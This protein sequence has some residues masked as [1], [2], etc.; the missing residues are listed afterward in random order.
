MN[1]NSNCWKWIIAFL[2]FVLLGFGLSPYFC[3]L[4][5]NN[6]DWQDLLVNVHPELIGM[7]FTILVLDFITHKYLER[8]EKRRILRNL[9]NPS[10]YFSIDAYYQ[11]KNKEWLTD[12]S[13]VNA[14]LSYSVLKEIDLSKVNFENVVLKKAHLERAIFVEA[15]LINAVFDEAHLEGCKFIRAHIEGAS[16]EESHLSGTDFTD[17]IYNSKTCWK[18]A[19]YDSKTN[20]P[21]EFSPEDAGCIRLDPKDIIT[22][23]NSSTDYNQH[24]M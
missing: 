20:W 7:G 19:T 12:G 5:S 24:M 14:Q 22:G 3:T 10:K 1:S 9:G 18:N 21:R 11:A 13:M 17:A 2:G 6:L 4:F 23:A 15:I 8:E 16:F